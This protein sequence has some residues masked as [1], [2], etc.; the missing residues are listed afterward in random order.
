[1]EMEKLYEREERNAQIE[2]E[3]RRQTQ[4]AKQVVPYQVTA[5]TSVWTEEREQCPETAHA[6]SAKRRTRK[7]Q[8]YEA[9]EALTTF[10]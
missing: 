1:M 7:K 3:K 2:R 9:D 4:R 10:E 8:K 5:F 6:Q